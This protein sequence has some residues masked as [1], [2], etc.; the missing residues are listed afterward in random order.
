[1]NTMM[2]IMKRWSA[3]RH[4]MSKTTKIRNNNNFPIITSDLQSDKGLQAN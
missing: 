3:S 2:N 1:M 4:N